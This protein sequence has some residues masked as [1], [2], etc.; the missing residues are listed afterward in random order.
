[1]STFS[2]QSEW[3]T[4]PQRQTGRQR[5]AVAKISADAAQRTDLRGIVADIKRSGVTSVRGIAAELN[6]RGIRAPRGDRWHP[7]AVARLLNRL[8]DT[9]APR[10]STQAKA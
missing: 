10:G 8:G 1:M 5:R 4:S 3:R 9:A 2:R 6:T 7:T